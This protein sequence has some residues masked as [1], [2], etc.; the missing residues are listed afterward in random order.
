[1]KK[2]KQNKTKQKEIHIPN[3]CISNWMYNDPPYPLPTHTHTPTYTQTSQRNSELTN[4]STDATAT[5]KP[6]NQ[7]TG[8]RNRNQ[9]QILGEIKHTYKTEHKQW[10]M[11]SGNKPSKCKIM[12]SG[13]KFRYDALRVNKKENSKLLLTFMGVCIGEGGRRNI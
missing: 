3:I 10:E 6:T 1:M 5:N 7:P 11:R 4:L 9:Q 2:S 12:G 8:K 13:T